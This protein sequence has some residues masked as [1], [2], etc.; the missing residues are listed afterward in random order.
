MEFEDNKL[1]W[2]EF[3]KFLEYPDILARSF[4][5]HG[6]TSIGAFSHLNVSESVG[7][8]PDSVKVNRSLIQREL[9]IENLLFMTQVHGTD[10]YVVEDMPISKEIVADGMITKKR[11]VGLAISH[12][13]CQAALFFDPEEDIIGALHVGWSGLVLNIYEK[14]V[15]SFLKMGSKSENIL[16]AISPSLGPS[17]A[18][19]KNYKKDFPKNFWDFQE[20]KNFF[21][22]WDI[23]NMLLTGAGILEENIEIV[24]KCTFSNPKDYYSYR[25]DKIT[26]RHASVI[27]LK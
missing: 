20:E 27:A 9:A 15:E 10:I 1:E 3:D 5:R 18:E 17:H 25:R 12:A 6:G 14:M 19:F 2:L 26:G 21:N 8:H 13:D 11:G 16:V 7:D 23:A 22:L 4:L 24:R